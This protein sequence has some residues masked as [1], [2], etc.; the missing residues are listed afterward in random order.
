MTEDRLI[1]KV[2]WVRDEM[3]GW[4]HSVASLQGIRQDV[5]SAI[6]HQSQ[7]SVDQ[8]ELAQLALGKAFWEKA[9]LSLHRVS[10]E[11]KAILDHLHWTNVREFQRDI[12]LWFRVWQ[13]AVFRHPQLGTRVKMEAVLDSLIDSLYALAAPVEVAVMDVDTQALAVLV[14]LKNYPESYYVMATMP[15]HSSTTAF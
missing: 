14:R 15:M 11:N 5:A 10:A 9:Q 7:A 12:Y 8:L 6:H 4:L 3:M 1:T 13:N 2:Q